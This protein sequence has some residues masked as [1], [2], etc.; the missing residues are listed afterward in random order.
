MVVINCK[1]HDTE[2]KYKESKDTCKVL[3]TELRHPYKQKHCL[4]PY[5]KYYTTNLLKE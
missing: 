1:K 3:C 2:S 5:C 4:S